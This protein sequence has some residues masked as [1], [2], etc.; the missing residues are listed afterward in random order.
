MHA[1][2]KFLFTL[3]L[4]ALAATASASPAEPKNGV[5]YLTLPDV[6]N[7]D[8][9]KKIEVTEFFAYYCP[10]CHSYEPAL[11]AWVKKQGDKINFKR[12]HVAHHPA[13]LPQ[14]R[15]YYTLEAM[16]LTEQYHNKVFAA[17]HEQNLRFASDEEVFN[18]VA[19]AGIDRV[20]F[21]E[22]Y[23]SFGMGAKVKQ[24][25]AMMSAYQLKQWPTIAIDGRYLTS[26]YQAGQGSDKNATETQQQQWSLQVMDHLVAKAKAEK[27]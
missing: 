24:A 26:P 5:E 13:V 21:I 20:K 16:G 4:C 9:G 23:R 19:S 7:T 27:K 22:A 17:I 1:T 25:M 8:S 10:H 11:S 18:W 14:Q 2:V 3:A 12:V 15:L 6:Q